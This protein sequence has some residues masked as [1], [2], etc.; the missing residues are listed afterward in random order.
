MDELIK[1][2]PK[3]SCANCGKVQP[4]EFATMKANDRNDHDAADILCGTWSFWSLP[5]TQS[6]QLNLLFKRQ[7]L[8]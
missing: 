7:D 3:V 8:N 6:L 5:C 2:F 1:R 4:M